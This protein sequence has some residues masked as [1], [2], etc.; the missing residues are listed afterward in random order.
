MRNQMPPEKEPAFEMTPMIDMVFL[1][2]VFFMIAS[3]LSQSQ[4]IPLEVPEA[5]K[6]VVP[7][8]R[9]DRWTI[10]VLADG[11]IF[12][13]SVQTELDSVADEVKARLAETPK[14]KVYIRADA[15]CPHKH[16]KKV[17]NKL[18]QVGVD[19]FIFATFKPSSAARTELSPE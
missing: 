17:M 5:D 9:P 2:L 13:G 7:K 19:D 10:N 3:R 8:E 16:V 1:L 6:S 18:T 14:L 12:S 15:T 11:T 4:S